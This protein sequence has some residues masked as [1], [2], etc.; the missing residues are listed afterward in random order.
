MVS[1]FDSA[2]INH[3]PTWLNY[4]YW[5]SEIL[6][7]EEKYGSVVMS[8]GNSLTWKSQHYQKM[9]KWVEA[10]IIML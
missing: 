3:L 4:K 10:H 8:N 6:S 1:I 5:E 7:L 9:W 2:S